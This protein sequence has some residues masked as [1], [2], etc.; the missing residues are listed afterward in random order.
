MNVIAATPAWAY[1]AAF[2]ASLFLVNGLPH[3]LHGISGKQFPT[4]FS[5]G[6]GTL[7]G[8]VRNVLWG[9][10]NLLAGGVLLWLVRHHLDSPALVAELVIVAIGGAS[11]LAAVFSQPEKFGRHRRKDQ[12]RDG[13]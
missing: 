5:G 7:D 2:F 4:P 13:P 3:F 8:A 10:A 6:A 12:S 1:L 9:S 11:L